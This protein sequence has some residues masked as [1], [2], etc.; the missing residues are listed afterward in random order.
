MLQ[1]APHEV[2]ATFGGEVNNRW[3]HSFDTGSFGG[4]LSGD[5]A[6][7]EPPETGLCF[8]L[9]INWSLKMVTPLFLDSLVFSFLNLN[10]EA[11]LLFSN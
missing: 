11:W 8:F 6:K 5:I 1:W 4:T 3:I 7:A 10:S 2:T 9:G